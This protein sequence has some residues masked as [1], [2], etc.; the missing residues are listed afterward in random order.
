M[1]ADVFWL[2]PK[3]FSIFSRVFFTFSDHK[4]SLQSLVFC[5]FWRYLRM[6]LVSR[7]PVCIPKR[8]AAAFFKYVSGSQAW[9]P[10]SQLPGWQEF[11]LSIYFNRHFVLFSNF[12]LLAR[13][14]LRLLTLLVSRHNLWCC[15]NY[16][17]NAWFYGLYPG[18]KWL[19][20]PH[21]KQ[22]SF[23]LKF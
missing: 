9:F 7:H 15:L 21:Q 4:W 8:P 14:H 12:P 16:R 20:P 3:N 13:L 6:S 22:Q 18:L 11:S 5:T 1:I 17:Q 2:L 10:G 19:V 23:L